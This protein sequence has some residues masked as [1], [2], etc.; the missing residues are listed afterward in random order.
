MTSKQKRL[1][2]KQLKF[3]RITTARVRRAYAQTKLRPI[4]RDWI[5]TPPFYDAEI[6]G[7]GL[8]P[9]HPWDGKTSLKDFAACALSAIAVAETITK[10]YPIWRL[11]AESVGTYLEL[12]EEY[13]DGFTDGFDGGADGYEYGSIAKIG[14][15]DGRTVRKAI[16]IP[17]RKR[18]T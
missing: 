3:T 11:D 18:G 13:V 7:T 12:P 17:K 2:K 4:N 10:K 15:Y 16:R 1:K 5:I 6:D 14:Y 9:K 8:G